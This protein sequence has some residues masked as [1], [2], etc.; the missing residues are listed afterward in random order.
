MYVLFF[1]VC[2]FITVMRWFTTRILDYWTLIKHVHMWKGSNI[3]VS[4]R[5]YLQ[6]RFY[7]YRPTSLQDFSLLT[8]YQPWKTK[9]QYLGHLSLKLEW[10]FVIKICQIIVK[11]KRNFFNSCSFPWWD[12]GKI[13]KIHGTYLTSSSEP[14]TKLNIKAFRGDRNSNLFKER[15][16]PIS[17]EG[18]IMRKK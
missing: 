3:R 10:T 6:N 2:T 12:S 11:S 14:V 18:G 1:A 4:R 15:D 5:A 16:M 17:K 9:L 13:V 7:C 8:S